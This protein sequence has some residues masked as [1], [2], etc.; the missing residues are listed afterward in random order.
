MPPVVFFYSGEPLSQYLFQITELFGSE[1]NFIHFSQDVNSEGIFERTISVGY[2]WSVLIEVTMS[3][4]MI[5]ES[6]RFETI[7][8]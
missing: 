3:H 4:I 6:K 8:L 7:D 1:V 2:K 5:L